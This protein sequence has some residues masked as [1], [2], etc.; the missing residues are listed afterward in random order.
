LVALLTINGLRAGYGNITVLHGIDLH[1]GEGEFVA[2]LGANG[3]GKST[4][5]KAILGLVPTTSGSIR[6]A[7]RDLAGCSVTR[8][9]RLGLGAIPEGRQ[10]FGDMTIAENL[11]SA[12]MRNAHS[13]H[14]RRSAP[15]RVC[16]TRFLG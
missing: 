3:A 16:S 7:D 6:F 9:I 15:C 5:L 8:R 2:V 14:R 11:A 13:A 1:V 12:S 4:L 10:L